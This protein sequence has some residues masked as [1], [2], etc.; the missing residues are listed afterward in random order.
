MFYGLDVHK[1]SIQVCQLSRNRRTRREFQSDGT[2]FAIEAFGKNTT[3][4]D[5][6]ALEATF[7]TRG[8]HPPHTARR[9]GRRGE[10]PAAEGDR[11]RQDRASL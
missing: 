9:K 10:P 3:R 7:H 11:T 5:Q 6:V 4:H 1:K 8:L 2:A